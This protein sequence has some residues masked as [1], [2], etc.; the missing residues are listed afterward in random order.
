MDNIRARVDEDE[1]D[2]FMDKLHRNTGDSGFDVDSLVQ[3]ILE[4]GFNPLLP[5]QGWNATGRP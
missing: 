5:K 3:S 4:E 1:R 2:E